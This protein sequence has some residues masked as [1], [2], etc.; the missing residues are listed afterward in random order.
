MTNEN[1]VKAL[2]LLAKSVE[3][4]QD[5]IVTLK[6]RPTHSDVN[7]HLT[8][9]QQ[10][11]IVSAISQDNNF[12]PHKKTRVDIDEDKEI[13][14]LDDIEELA[15]QL[16]I[17]VTLSEAATTFLE[18][19]FSSKLSNDSRQARINTH[20][21]PDSHWT[22]CP[23]IDAMVVANVSPVANKTDRAASHLQQ[24]YFLVV[25]FYLLLYN[26]SAEGL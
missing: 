17:V 24:V 4:I 9:L 20:G 22:W 25:K 13:D 19:S 18:A 23:K 14:D 5:D 12:P 26:T 21:I 16:H 2:A 15:G 6:R 3:S 7:P 1:V 11:D 8:G 10:S